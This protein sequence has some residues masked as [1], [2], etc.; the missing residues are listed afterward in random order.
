MTREKRTEKF[1]LMM[2]PDEIKAIDDWSFRH[3][4]RTRAEAIRRL[5]QLGM[6]ASCDACGGAAT[7][8]RKL[9][10]GQP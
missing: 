4:V 9:D 2:S 10:G 5:C 6:V 1:Q 7:Q 3:R 8:A